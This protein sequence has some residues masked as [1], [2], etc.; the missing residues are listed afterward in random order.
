MYLFLQECATR[1]GDRGPQTDKHLPPST[2]SFKKSRHLGFG[3]FLSMLTVISLFGTSRLGA[4][5][6]SPAA[7]LAA[8]PSSLIGPLRA[9]GGAATN[10]G[11][12]HVLT[13]RQ[14]L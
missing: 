3:V 10:G 4:L 12:L 11:Q 9:L 7:H 14:V 8:S 5:P 6:V 13:A 1:G 2:L